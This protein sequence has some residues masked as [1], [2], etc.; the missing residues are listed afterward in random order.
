MKLP[1]R[2]PNRIPEYDY[3]QTGAYFVTVCTRNRQ[4]ILSS[5]VGTPLL[6][7]PNETVMKTELLRYGAIADKFIRQMDG[8]YAS[9]SV[10]KY[11][12]MP[13][14]IHLLITIHTE[15]GHPGRGVPTELHQAYATA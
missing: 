10:D 1:N 8:F 13:D 3:S 6:G 14:H 5:I 7:C 11:V 4:K 9:L 12:I 15:D 2:Q